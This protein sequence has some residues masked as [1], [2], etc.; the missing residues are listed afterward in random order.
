MRDVKEHLVLDEHT[1]IGR[2]IYSH[3]GIKSAHIMSV[4][5][6]KILAS[7]LAKWFSD[8]SYSIKLGLCTFNF[9]NA[10]LT[11]ENRVKSKVRLDKTSFSDHV[12]P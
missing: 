2:A 3:N 10:S 4:L 6:K 5:I 8:R 7:I 1:N 9:L 12:T 11:L